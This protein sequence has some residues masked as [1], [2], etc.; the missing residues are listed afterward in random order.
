MGASHQALETH[1]RNVSGSGRRNSHEAQRLNSFKK[2]AA[3]ARPGSTLGHRAFLVPEALA[4]IFKTCDT[5]L[6]SR[7]HKVHKMLSNLG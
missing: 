6:S 7:E 3:G 4:L 5:Y 2:N 1:L